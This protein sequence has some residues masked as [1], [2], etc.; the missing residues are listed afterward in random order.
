MILT[1][2]RLPRAAR[3]VARAASAIAR[4]RAGG[5]AVGAALLAA[6]AIVLAACAAALASSA[7]S[8][9]LLYNGGFEAGSDGWV[10]ESNGR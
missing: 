7:S 10:A 9:N 2:T 1:V 4:P 3:F 5:G 8:G 6:S